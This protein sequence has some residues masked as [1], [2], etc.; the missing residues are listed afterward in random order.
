MVHIKS[1]IVTLRNIKTIRIIQKGMTVTHY[2]TNF[3]EVSMKFKLFSLVFLTQNIKEK[4]LFAGDVGFIVKHH[5]A[6]DHYSKGYEV[7]FF[8]ALVD[9]LA[10]VSLTATKLLAGIGDNVFHVRKEGSSFAMS[11][12]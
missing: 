5:P 7:E 10:V 11:Y 4:N 3:R 8:A 1:L 6:A 12:I 2:D 9:T